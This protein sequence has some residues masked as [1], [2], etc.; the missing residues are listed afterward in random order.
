MLAV[1]S[2]SSAQT[3]RAATYNCENAF[4][5]LHDEGHNDHEF[6][7]EGTHRWSRARMYRK[8]INI[9]KVIASIDSLRPVDVVCLC[10]V[11]NDSVLTWLTHNTP[12]TRLGYEYVMTH[13][14]D[15]RGVDVALLYTPLTFR[16][17]SSRSLRPRIDGHT[18][19]VLHVTG[20]V[21]SGDT[22]DI[23]AVHLP[24]KLRGK[25]SEQYRRVIAHQIM[26]TVDSLNIVR[27]NPNILV[28]GDFNDDARSA[29]LRKCFSTL[30]NITDNFTS[31]PNASYKYHGEWSTIDQ[32]LINENMHRRLKEVHVVSH[33]F[34]LEPDVKYG[35]MKPR[36]TF[37]GWKY[38]DGFSDHLPVT[39]E[40]RF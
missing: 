5:T 16:P 7:P 9:S 26:E 4:D 24:S 15:E 6:L 31:P 22:L 39:A 35:G 27:T 10:E 8:L 28:M 19:D 3:F 38:N 37:V 17:I 23:F 36:R 40:F 20:R 30:I 25:T 1:S 21:F 2:I 18:R 13:S 11:E 14:L 29:T 33:D 32:I 34:L 12:L